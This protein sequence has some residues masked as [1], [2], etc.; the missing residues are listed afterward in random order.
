L[1]GREDILDALTEGVFSVDSEWRITSFNRAA[2]RITGV[3]REEAMGRLCC[4]VF[5]AS[6]CEEACALRQTLET[7]K[8]VVGKAISIVDAEG[9]RIPIS[10]S[11][12]IVR[13]EEG[14]AIGG[15]ETFRDLSQVEALRKELEKSYTFSDIIG[16]SPSM[17]ELFDRLPAIA[18]SGS[19][20]LIQGES[21]TGKE[22]VARAVHQLSA[23]K[24]KPFVAVNCA[25][26]P[27]TLLESELFGHK[28]GA[29]TDAKRDKPGRFSLADGGTLFLDEIGDLPPSMQAKLLRVL[30]EK[31]IEPLGGVWPV[32]VDVRVIAATHRDLEKE[33][34]R[35]TFREDLY[36]RIQV[37][38]VE[39][40]PLRERKEDIPL[41]IDHFVG[42]F[43]VR[44]NK[45][46]SG[47]SARALSAL[48]AHDF[49]GNVR[50]LE[51]AL[52]HAFVLSSGGLIRSKDLPASVT[53]GR[54]SGQAPP[55]GATLA[56]MERLWIEAALERNGGH[57]HA[58]AREL[59]I[60]PSTLY[61]KI[62]SWES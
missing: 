21:G 35:E 20:V 12:A 7:G 5:H 51:H 24:A 33:V 18:E 28:A 36:Y 15:A 61:R 22:L 1:T 11:T 58:A 29:F 6:I 43:K 14:H 40:P 48:M 47:V 42:R 23:R 62:K 17:Q 56:E 4:E 34:R 59:G 60:H 38:G 19:T 39:L 53:G 16:R 45:D 3:S 41:L 27:D 37:V 10:I 52:E 2:E 9:N 8:P 54:R 49:P 44:M 55:G 25:A 26:L 30:E 31:V 32:S 50:E 13:D 46:V 57:R